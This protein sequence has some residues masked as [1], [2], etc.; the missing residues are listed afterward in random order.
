V[1]ELVENEIDWFVC[2][3]DHGQFHWW[4]VGTS[5]GY[6]HCFAFRWDGF[7]WLMVDPLGC[8]LE[9]QVLPYGDQDNVPQM[10]TELGHKVIYVRK[11]RENKFIFRGLTTCVNMVKHLIGVKAFWVITPRQLYN[12]LQGKDYGRIIQFTESTTTKRI[13]S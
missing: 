7:N 10:M 9:I 13:S 5:E 6:R 12:Y 3:V 8:W 4:D 1:A 2:F 11:N